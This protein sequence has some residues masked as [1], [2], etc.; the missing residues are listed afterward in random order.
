MTKTSPFK[1]LAVILL[2]FMKFEETISSNL[3]NHNKLTTRFQNWDRFTKS[4]LFANFESYHFSF[5]QAHNVFKK[6]M[7][8]YFLTLRKQYT[9]TIQKVCGEIQNQFFGK[10]CL[11][12]LISYHSICDSGEKDPKLTVCE[13]LHK[14]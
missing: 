6:I 12:T 13:T 5:P 3:M 8:V 7:L 2:W 10:S 14:I 4:F 1:N 9:F 11:Q